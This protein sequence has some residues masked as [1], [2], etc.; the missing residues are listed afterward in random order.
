MVLLRFSHRFILCAAAMMATGA[1]GRQACAVEVAWQNAGS[2]AWETPGNWSGPFGALTPLWEFNEAGVI[3]NGGTA[4]VAVNRS[5][6]LPSSE[7]QGVAGVRIGQT[8]IGTLSITAGGN[9]TS[10]TS[11][12]AGGEAGTVNVGVNGTGTLLMNGTQPSPATLSTSALS[13]QGNVGS[14]VDLSGYSNLTVTN[15]LPNAPGGTGA[16]NF[17]RNLRITGPNVNLTATGNVTVNNYTAV[18]T[19]ASHSAIKTPGDFLIRTGGGG[20]NLN[21]QFSGYTPMVGTTWTL[22]DVGSVS[23]RWD[24]IAVG[25]A[26]P[27]TGA[28]IPVGA[29]LRLKATPGGMNGQQLQV[30]LEANLVLTVNRDTGEMT[31]RNPQGAPVTQLTGYD[32]A[33]PRGS[34]LSAYKGISGAPAGNSGWEKADTNNANGLAEFK[35]VG[36]FNVSSNATNVS[37][38]TGWSKLAYAQGAGLGGLGLTGEDLTFRYTTFGG[39][40]VIGQVEYVGTPFANNL[41]VVATPVGQAMLKNDSTIPLSIDGYII[42]STTGALSGAAW[43][44]LADRPEARF[45]GWEETPASA[46]ALAESNP[47][48]TPVLTIQPGE[49]FP[50][51]DIG[52]FST[53]AAQGGLS[54]TF[55]LDGVAIERAGSVL[56]ASSLGLAGDFDSNGR[57]DGNDFLVWQRNFSVGSLAAWRATYGQTN[58]TATIAAVPEPHTIG[59]SVAALALVGALRRNRFQA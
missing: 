26:V 33:S 34:L 48:L 22:A 13:V 24:N 56:I 16:I 51:G 7:T 18:I 42:G 39:A 20:S 45:N 9:L 55:I 58:A 49:S 25:G 53:A 59:L 57:V 1:V 38:G 27:F 4:V 23:S 35:P 2:G 21:L 52:D 46:N 11:A 14:L 40:P 5:E 37:L 19:G 28:T 41:A 32:I 31:L 17:D 54:L 15:A 3:N 29:S 8:G 44:S 47:E 10:G 6:L 12:T 50:L 30:A 43:T 36:S